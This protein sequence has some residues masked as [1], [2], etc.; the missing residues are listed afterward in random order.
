M[1]GEDVAFI[2]LAEHASSAPDGTFTL[3]RAGL[4]RVWNETLPM[5]LA[6]TLFRA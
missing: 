5:G 3:V 4:N 1:E 2:T 6:A